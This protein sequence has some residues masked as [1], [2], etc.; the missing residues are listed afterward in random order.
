MQQAHDRKAM[1]KKKLLIFAL[2]LLVLATVPTVGHYLKYQQHRAST[3]RSLNVLLDKYKL[4]L[5]CE[6]RRHGWL[7]QVEEHCRLQDNKQLVWLYMQQRVHFYPTQ[8]KALLQITGAKDAASLDN[9]I[10]IAGQW[11]VNTLSKT[12]SFSLENKAIDGFIKAE[13]SIKFQPLSLAGKLILTPPFA[14]QVQLS[15]EQGQ[16]EQ[17]GQ[18]LLLFQPVLLLA[19]DIEEGLPSLKRTKLRLA[20]LEIKQFEQ[21]FQ[22]GGLTWQQQPALEGAGMGMHENRLYFTELLYRA[23]KQQ[24]HLAPSLVQFQWRSAAKLNQLKPSWRSW[25][26]AL[27]R[28]GEL[29]ITQLSTSMDYQNYDD[30]TLR[31]SGDVQASGELTLAPST[32]KPALKDWP[33][34]LEAK[35]SLDFSPSLLQ[36]LHAV[37]VQDF[38][39]KG[40]LMQQNGRI[41]TELK[42]SKGILLANER[43]VSTQSLRP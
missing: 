22:F 19:G 5:H 26:R 12:L 21:Q 7:L 9:L 34:K 30:E 24:L 43:L 27:A 35:L 29:H 32:A 8:A 14:W 18:S 39:N 23:P 28:G 3:L 17:L 1:M 11:Q 4:S 41:R 36:E 2:I 38:L 20:R 31:L 6:Q 37:Q 33:F 40:W 15:S 10:K 13:T 16:L 42:F 25:Q